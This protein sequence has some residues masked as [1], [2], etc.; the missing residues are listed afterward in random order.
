[1]NEGE[2]MSAQINLSNHRTS[3]GD[4]VKPELLLHGEVSASR[5]ELEALDAATMLY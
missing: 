3:L 2:E 1:M 4:L 5:L